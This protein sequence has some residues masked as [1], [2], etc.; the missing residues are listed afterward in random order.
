MYM[1][2]TSELERRFGYKRFRKGQK[3]II[4]A[5][6]QGKSVIGRL[7]TGSG[8]SLCYIFPADYIEGLFLIISPLLALMEDQV[9]RLRME[10]YKNVAAL[11]SLRTIEEKKN[12]FSNLHRLKFLFISPEMLQSKYVLSA[13]QDVSIGMFVIDEAHCISKWG[14]DFRPDYLRIQNFIKKYPDVPVLALTATATKEIIEDITK[15]LCL[16]DSERIISSVNRE[17]IAIITDKVENETEKIKKL[18]QF[19]MYLPKPMLIYCNRRKTTE[20]LYEQLKSEKSLSD[21]QMSFFHGGLDGQAKMIL[22]EQYVSGEIDIMI[23]TNA[24][25]MGIHKDDIRTVIHFNPPL[26]YEAY[27]QEMGRAGRDQ[28]PACSVVL[29]NDEDFHK[30]EQLIAYEHLEYDQIRTYLYL[31]YVQ[32]E[33]I[34]HKMLEYYLDMSLE[35]L[36][37]PIEMKKNRAFMEKN[38]DFYTKKIYNY[39]ISRRQINLDACKKIQ[40]FFENHMLCR[41]V[42]LLNYFGEHKQKQEGKCCDVCGVTLLDFYIEKSEKKSHQQAGWLERLQGLLRPEY[43]EGRK[44]DSEK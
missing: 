29:W 6:I 18:I 40:L 1:D 33:V 27:L 19:T 42:Q 35:M 10:G 23:C 5:L 39:I 34:W 12:I 37:V 25:G 7:P 26:Q 4:S 31:R 16:S 21:W 41:R 9:Y 8:K 2:L 13:L 36:D 32:T 11:N 44:H 28:K 14:Y 22:T 43:I 17:N 15:H 20:Q 38:I 24:F 3:E 30:N